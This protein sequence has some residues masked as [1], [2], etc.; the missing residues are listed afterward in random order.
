MG[1]EE[2][3]IP[4]VRSYCSADACGWDDL[5]ARACNG[6][7]L[8][9][10]S[11][12]SYHGDRFRDRSL[13][14]E[15]RR[16]RMV[17]VL[18][19]AEAPSDSE[20]IISHPG[21]S[22]GGVVHDGTLR[23]AVMVGALDAIASHYRSLGYR[24]LRYKAVPSIFHA[25]PAEDDLYALFRLGARRHQ[26]DLSVAIDLAERGR[27]TRRRRH[28]L[29]WAEREGVRVQEAWDEIAGFWR[30]LERNLASRHNAS[31]VHSL[32]EI[33]M[34]R[35]KF[36]D[37]ICL[38]NAKIDADLVGGVLLFLSD[39]VSR[40]QYTATTER[41]RAACASDPVM[42]H[43]IEIAR[44]RGCRYFDF[45]TCTLDAGR[46]LHQNLY[47]FKASFGGAGVLYEHYEL[48]LQLMRTSRWCVCMEPVVAV[49]VPAA[50]VN[51][52]SP[53]MRRAGW[54]HAIGGK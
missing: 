40:A 12:I 46:S 17:G 19:A 27:V 7:F 24:R 16:K 10:R 48:D 9:T 2:V 14:L 50:P 13:V 39:R 45:G 1:I 32:A 49:V 41:G 53:G 43:A 25:P 42:E 34:L 4:V 52:R 37:A 3:A 18:P 23:G 15:N 29:S 21:L 54:T 6:T 36:P 38:I 22:Y 33:Q 31:P 47:H 28:S 20:V 30:L 44:K 35:E 5:V 11:F 8:H 51:R 26:C